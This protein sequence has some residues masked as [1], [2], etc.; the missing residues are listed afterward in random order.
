[1][2][3]PLPVCFL[4]LSFF[5]FYIT[6]R[7]CLFRRQIIL[8]QRRQDSNIICY[9]RTWKGKLDTLNF[10][11]GHRMFY[12]AYG[13]NMSHEQMKERC[14][15]SRFVGRAFLPEYSFVY[16]GYF[17]RRGGAVGNV[18]PSKNSVVWGGIFE[19]SE[20]TSKAWIALGISARLWATK[21]A[22]ERRLGRQPPSMDLSQ[23]GPET[24]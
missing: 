23:T 19:I 13:S 12:F 2:N 9:M 11:E 20:E 1:M 8:F 5:L 18:A 6:F 10:A 7:S 24:W 3:K 17:E 4:Q 15:D 21:A 14:P 22:G 16:D